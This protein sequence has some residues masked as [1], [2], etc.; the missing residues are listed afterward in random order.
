[1]SVFTPDERRALLFL[2]A[3]AA[4]GGVGRAVRARA[5]AAAPGSALIAPEIRG[6]DV[7]RQAALA[8]RA[9][10][11]ARPLAP[12]ERVDVDAAP[13]EEIERL[14]RVG[15]DLAR[16]IAEDREAHGPFGSL[17]GLGRVPGIGPA[18]L[19]GFEKWVR[20]SGVPRLP[21]GAARGLPP[22]ASR[23]RST[24][25]APAADCRFPV[26]LNSAT[27]EHLACL[28]GIGPSLAERIVTFR[29]ARGP[30]RE[31]K[32]LQQ[33]PGIGPSRMT[34]LAPLISVP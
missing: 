2:A 34:R 6:G 15:P 8:R 17:E 27:A 18:T 31:V 32:A 14:P 19:A 1:M 16:R 5:P 7:A 30:F 4:A 23:P 22:P 28:P 21:A 11:L 10:E 13:P 25:A 20:F 24:A 9:A 29:T 33:V 3:V 12:G 26:P